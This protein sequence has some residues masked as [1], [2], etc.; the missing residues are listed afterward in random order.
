M[1]IFIKNKEYYKI[2]EPYLNSKD[3]KKLDYVKH[4]NTT[5]LN[6]CLKVSYISYKIAKKLGFDFKSVAVGGLLHDLYYNLVEDEKSFKDKAKLF[7]YRH[8]KDALKNAENRFNLNE[9]EKEIIYSH[10]WPLSF[11]MVPK[12]KESIL[13]SLVDKGVSIKEFSVLWSYKASYKF[14]VYFVFISNLLFYR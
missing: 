14:G 9:L 2:I 10:M 7:T 13:V 3:V 5:R 12:H 4:H 1:N 8:P 11:F 6:H